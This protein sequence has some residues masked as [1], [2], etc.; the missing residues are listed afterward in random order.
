[1][2]DTTWHRKDGVENNPAPAGWLA[3]RV[4]TFLPG[5]AITPRVPVKQFVRGQSVL[6]GD[7]VLMLHPTD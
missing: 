4:A 7:P 5:T 2:H 6:P 1:M 3:S